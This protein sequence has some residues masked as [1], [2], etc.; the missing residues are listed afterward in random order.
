MKRLVVVILIAIILL[1]FTKHPVLATSIQAYTD[2]QYQF[3]LYRQ[4]YSDFQVAKNEYLKFKSLTSQSEALDGT[5]KM[6]SQRDALL[7]SYLLVLKEKLNE[8]Q[9][10]GSQDRQ[11]YQSLI[12]NEVKFLEDHIALIPSVAALEDAEDVSRQLESHYLVLQTS[13]RQTLVALALGNL[14]LQSNKLDEIINLSKNLLTRNA[15]YL[16]PEKRSILERWLVQIVNKKTLYRQKVELIISANTQLKGSSL[17]DLDQ[18]I[19]LMQK[20]LIG[21]KQYL[22]EAASFL[23]EFL[24]TLQ[25]ID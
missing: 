2:Y 12:V 5:K 24:N 7:R 21:G 23:N 11:L 16:S 1:S 15:G 13:V 4:K 17:I 20:E 18:Q 8:N 3:D 6:L 9:G 14:S 10:I 22:A 19:S 25:Y